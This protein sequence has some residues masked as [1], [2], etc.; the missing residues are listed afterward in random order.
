MIRGNYSQSSV[1][2]RAIS[3]RQA[4]FAGADAVEV[5]A[6]EEDAV[7]VVASE[8]VA[9]LVAVA[10]SAVAAA[11]A[12][13]ADFEAVDFEVAVGSGEVVASAEV[14]QKRDFD[15]IN[16]SYYPSSRILSRIQ[17]DSW[18]AFCLFVN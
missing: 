15:P 8:A 12:E 13:A 9:A 3:L 6:D 5:L 16:S 14:L 7:A 17:V 1:S 18:V 4:L 11:V 2:F 10:D